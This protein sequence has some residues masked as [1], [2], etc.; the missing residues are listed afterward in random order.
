MKPEFG[1]LSP[2]GRW[3]WDGTTWVPVN[4]VRQPSA[5]HRIGLLAW[6]LVLEFFVTPLVGWVLTAGLI[7]LVLILFYR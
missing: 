6:D 7:L 5:G 3:S 2:D 1:E 4:P